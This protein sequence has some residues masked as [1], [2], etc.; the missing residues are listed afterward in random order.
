MNPLHN[1]ILAT[2]P[3]QDLQ[4]LLP[5]LQLVS[6]VQGHVLFETGEIPE[7]VYFPVGA[8]VSMINDLPDGETI[9]LHMLGK[10]CM[11]GV[12]AIDTPSF[13]RA[14][15]RLSGLAYRLRLEVLKNYRKNSPNYLVQAQARYALLMGHI[16]QRA[17]CIRYHNIEQQVIR[18]AM[19]MLDRQDDLVIHVTHNELATLM[20][21][22][23][24]G[25]TL[26]LGNLVKRGVVGLER[27]CIHVLDRPALEMLSCDCYWN[28]LGKPHPA[29]FRKSGTQDALA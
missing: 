9:E 3:T 23:R 11:V 16:A 18:W 10:T 27:G 13:Y 17:I 19:L 28:A 12:A 24:E 1:A 22:R 29:M 7:H 14:S 20:G 21:A 8:I 5:H 25:I 15:V 2:L 26:A 6:L 4:K